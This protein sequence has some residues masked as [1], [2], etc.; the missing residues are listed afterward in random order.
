MPFSQTTTF[1]VGRLSESG[2]APL[3]SCDS[4]PTVYQQTWRIRRALKASTSE[5]SPL[6]IFEGTRK[7]PD[8]EMSSQQKQIRQVAINFDYPSSTFSSLNTNLQMTTQDTVKDECRPARLTV[9]ASTRVKNGSDVSNL[10]GFCEPVPVRFA[11][12]DDNR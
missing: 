2:T 1:P 4:N 8:Y 5:G 11:V 7:D 10:R 3:S 9:A 12:R 6:A